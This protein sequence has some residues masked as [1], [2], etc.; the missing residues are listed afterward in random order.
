MAD[1]PSQF[2]KFKALIETDGLPALGPQLRAGT[3]SGSELDRKLSNFFTTEKVSALAQP[4]LRGAALLWHDH[5]DASHSVSQEIE[6]RE[7]SWLHG[8]MHRREPD[9]G[10]AK[11]WFRRVGRHE[12]FPK[13]AEQVA[14]LQSLDAAPELTGLIE[15]GEWA[16]FVFVDLCAGA[17][18]AKDASLTAILKQV[19]AIE[20]DVLIQHVLA[21]A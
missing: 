6:S 15:K 16:P 12:A 11:Y 13:L 8:I 1:A 7:G 19:Q 18:Q 5:L 9:Y 14:A 2:S 4:L 20:F 17:E 3:A 10:N 21:H